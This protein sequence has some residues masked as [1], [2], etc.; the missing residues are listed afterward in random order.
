MNT[1]MK[2]FELSKL[3]QECQ[4]HYL[5]LAKAKFLFLALL[6]CLIQMQNTVS[7]FSFLFTSNILTLWATLYSS[8]S[9]KLKGQV[10]ISKCFSETYANLKS[11]DLI[12]NKPHS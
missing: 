3:S 8:G 1:Y 7:V 5:P 9:R 6:S 4:E 10:K 12:V 2:L 11:S